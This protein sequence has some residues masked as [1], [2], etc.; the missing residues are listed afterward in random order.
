MPLGRSMQ[1]GRILL[2]CCAALRV[3][4]QGG[5]VWDN[6]D[7]DAAMKFFEATSDWYSTWNG[8]DAAMQVQTAYD[9]MVPVYI[10]LRS[11]SFGPPFFSWRRVRFSL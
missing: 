11:I 5:K 1:R 9:T 3:R 8:K 6:S 4:L 2:F 10:F 7:S